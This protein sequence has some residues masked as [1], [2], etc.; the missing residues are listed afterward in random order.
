MTGGEP[1]TGDI[2][3]GITL[4]IVKPDEVPEKTKKNLVKEATEIYKSIKRRAA[5]EAKLEVDAKSKEAALKKSAGDK[6]GDV[7]A[8]EQEIQAEVVK[9]L[10]RYY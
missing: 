5:E 1:I 8:A 4:N 2:G 9:A 7:K 3:N 6:G 10:N